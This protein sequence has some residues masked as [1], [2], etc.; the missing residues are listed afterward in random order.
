MIR[1]TTTNAIAARVAS[2][3]LN[4]IIEPA[5]NRIRNS[6]IIPATNNRNPIENVILRFLFIKDVLQLLSLDI[7]NNLY[8]MSIGLR[9]YCFGSDSIEIRFN[10]EILQ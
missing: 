2:K 9:V 3:V 4:S 7:A 6:I 8:R 5:M 1:P 10:L